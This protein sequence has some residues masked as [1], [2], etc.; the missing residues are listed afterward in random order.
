[1]DDISDNL[2]VLNRLLSQL[3]FEI[4]EAVDG[5]D[6]LDKMVEFQPDL[7]LLDL[8]MPGMS[9]FD[10]VRHIRQ[11]PILQD[12]VIIILSASAFDQTKQESLAIG[13]DDFIT[14][15]FDMDELLV[16]LET[17]LE[18]T[19][20]YE[21]TVETE[22]ELPLESESTLIIPQKEELETLLKLATMQNITGV[23]AYLEHINLLDSKFNR[24][25]IEIN[26]L[27]K[28]YYFEQIIEFIKPYL[29]V[30]IK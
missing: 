22:K 28:K 8:V 10:V 1:V 23:Q 25:A 29:G 11:L 7:I 2:D 24:F 30:G 19:W 12:T 3:G 6:C 13:C 16:K 15:P 4:M 27:A 20:L 21:E 18:L 9:G 26:Q 14:K 5:Q 17:N